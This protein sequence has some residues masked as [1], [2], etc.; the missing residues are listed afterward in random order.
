MD[1]IQVFLKPL[2]MKRSQ[3]GNIWNIRD[4]KNNKVKENV[5][6]T[7]SLRQGWQQ[8][9]LDKSKEDRVSHANFTI[10]TFTASSRI[11]SPSSHSV[12]CTCHQ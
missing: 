10:D 2:R 11:F 7:E 4:E 3:K 5:F 9:K 1:E 12:T 6:L 8:K